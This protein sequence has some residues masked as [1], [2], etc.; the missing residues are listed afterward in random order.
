MTLQYTKTKRNL[1]S[2]I[3]SRV[4]P[5][6]ASCLFYPQPYL[7]LRSE[8]EIAKMELL[9]LFGVEIDSMQW[10]VGITIKKH[11]LRNI[12]RLTFWEKVEVFS[13][14]LPTVIIPNQVLLEKSAY[15]VRA[16][17]NVYT[18]DYLL[19]SIHKINLGHKKESRY[20]MHSLHSYKGKFHPQIVKGLINAAGASKGE[21]VLDPFCG[22]G[23]TNLECFFMG[24]NSW[25]VDFNPLACLIAQVRI[26]SLAMDT[27]K[28]KRHM[29]VLL[30]DVKKKIVYLQRKQLSEHSRRAGQGYLHD[31]DVS[32]ENLPVE[33]TV[34][35]PPE[36]PNIDK[37]FDKETLEQL[38]L[39]RNSIED[40]GDEK[41]RRFF[42][43]VLSSIIKEVS[44]WDISQVRPLLRK[45]PLRNVDVYSLC[46]ENLWK[47]F[48]I[49]NVY[50]KLKDALNLEDPFTRIVNA[51]SRHLEFLDD[52]SVDLVVTSPPYANALPY[53]ETDRLRSIL[54][55]L[56]QWEDLKNL[57]QKEI[58]NREITPGE[59]KE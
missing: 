46:K 40:V 22:C 23:T 42:L 20:L 12:D 51:D 55:G 54:I 3:A 29:E 17:R 58:G 43:V 18:V 45:E 49:V 30:D 31:Y 11:L 48:R 8:E 33:I 39:I 15:M 27:L 28:L 57:R 41:I 25:G 10:P 53:I 38:L 34:P 24:I 19:R 35:H 6:E 21:V 36:L 16:S 59:K 2:R 50:S 14:N 4:Q 1:Q 26:E 56:F 13:N 5:D 44:N 32:N 52:D 9:S 7:S 47:A 37:W